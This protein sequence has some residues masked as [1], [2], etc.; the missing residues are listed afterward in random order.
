MKRV[1]YLSW[2]FFAG[3]FV[4]L[5]HPLIACA[6]Q[7]P[8]IEAF[9][10]D[11]VFGNLSISPSGKFLA[12]TDYRDRNDLVVIIDLST[13]EE[14][15][16]INQGNS[17][18]DWVLW[19]SE[20][21][22]LVGLTY[23][24][25]GYMKDEGKKRSADGSVA[26]V[27]RVNVHRV[28]AV[29]RDG[30]ER[31]IMFDNA[32]KGIRRNVDLSDVSDVL[33]QDPDHILMPAYDKVYELWKVNI[34]DGSMSKVAKGTGQTYRWK[35]NRSGEPVVRY[36]RSKNRQYSIVL[37]REAGSKKWERVATLRDQDLE[38][39]NPIAPT[40]DPSIY[41]V[42][43]R[44]TGHDRIA[45]FTYSLSDKNFLEKISGSEVVDLKNV[46]V[47]GLGNLY[48]SQY[49]EK[50]QSYDFVDNR[51]E[52]HL[53]G[54]ETFFG[55]DMNVALYDVAESG[56]DWIIFVSG[57]Q[58]PGSF[59]HYNLDRKK[60]DF[61]LSRNY[62]LEPE[63]LGKMS[64]FEYTS[65]D[66]MKLSGY[67]THA[68]NAEKRPAPLIVM[69]HGGPQS[70]TY[71]G[72]SQIVQFF[73]ARGYQVFQP[74]FRG[75][76]GFGAEF[77]AR[78]Y[79]EWGGKMQDDI[80]DGVKHLIQTGKA[81]AGNICIVGASFGGYAALAGAVKTP[82]L[83]ECAVSLNGVSDLALM[84]EYDTERFKDSPSLVD[85]MKKSIGD[86]KMDIDKMRLASPAKNA[87]SVTIPILL[88]HGT[89]DQRV[90]VA[91]SRMMHKALQEAGKSSEFIE[92]ENVGH[93]FDRVLDPGERDTDPYES[94]IKALSAIEVFLVESLP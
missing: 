43:A 79:G 77:E 19:A 67:L 15:T 34:H 38:L 32:R 87:D 5:T 92:L 58:E 50:S 8:S 68:V 6:Q 22:L 49:A 36:D 51:L 2:V 70:R 9:F 30:G 37:M 47:D 60:A 53:T 20:D 75:S 52:K 45:V 83:Y 65:R 41:Y 64:Y 35:T 10:P 69:P 66:N 59:Y 29:D 93:S 61:L 44:P 33:P 42:A 74:N 80:T 78:G 62:S 26:P 81:Q 89:Q 40:D 88:I 76:R 16:R 31:L 14:I 39:F 4:S 94:W 91:Q 72:Y 57:P 3:F 17:E 55:K 13:K 85:F 11:P 23:F 25:A 28:M 1:F 21:R 18:I 7:P 63:Q 90:P 56:N 73:S 27:Q 12:F 48:A 24:I 82:D 46:F 84:I 71:Y 54:L 86:P